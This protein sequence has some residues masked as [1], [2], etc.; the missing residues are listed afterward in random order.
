LSSSPQLEILDLRHFSAAQL[1]PLLRDEAARWQRRLHWNYTRA[2]TMLLD[3]LD[4]RVLPGFVA[5]QSGNIVGYA[6]CIFE[7]SKAVIGDVYAFGETEST[8]NPICDTLLHHLLELLQATPGIDRVE[9]QLLMFPSG[10]LAEPFR[11]RGFRSFPRCF[12]MRDLEALAACTDSAPPSLPPGVDLLLQSWQPEFHEGAAELIHRSYASHMD[13]AINDQYCTLY[14]AQRFLH[15]IIR[16]PGCGV[17]D[18]ENSWVLRN[19][20]ALE[21]ASGPLGIIPRV[22]GIEAILLCSRV[23]SDV[24]HITQLCIS[25]SLRSHGLGQ[26]LLDQCA[27]ESAKRGVK[28]L[29][30]TVTEANTPALHLYERNGFTTLHRFE[31]M[32]WDA[33]PT[34]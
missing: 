20:G 13:A 33:S 34:A 19:A 9:S 29:S 21:C 7:G 25:P 18:A 6:F 5:L 11:S 22:R 27:V 28:A 32:V 16:F 17:F 1:K 4:G 24:D 8:V 15:N 14:G 23:R 3:Y 31:A 26:V 12:M 10:A 2:S 30:L